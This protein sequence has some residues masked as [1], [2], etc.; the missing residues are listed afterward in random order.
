MP[1]M[2]YWKLLLVEF[3]GSSGQSKNI[4]RISRITRIDH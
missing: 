2:C 1:L 4:P 3:R